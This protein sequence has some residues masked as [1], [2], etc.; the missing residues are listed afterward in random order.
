[1]T[2]TRGDTNARGQRQHEVP[3]PAS[4]RAP[5]SPRVASNWTLGRREATVASAIPGAEYSLPQW[6]PSASA[7]QK[8]LRIQTRPQSR[9]YGTLIV[10]ASTGPPLNGSAGDQS[11]SN[12][13]A[14]PQGNGTARITQLP[15]AP[16]LFSR[17]RVPLR[18]PAMS[19]RL[20]SSTCNVLDSPTKRKGRQHVRPA[21]TSQS[22]LA[23]LGC[24]THSEC[25]AY[26]TTH[27]A[28][29]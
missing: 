13:S 27:G 4:G 19:L 26:Y 22:F 18:C 5:P 20:Q 1:M 10:P 6:G 12:R 11:T 23:N 24:C 21:L 25:T 28:T 14:R 3:P 2:V 17:A 29:A 15:S 8:A 16:Y 7:M 9:P